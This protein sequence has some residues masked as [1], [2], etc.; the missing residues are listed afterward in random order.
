MTISAKASCNLIPPVM[1]MDGCGQHI[2]DAVPDECWQT[3]FRGELI[4]AHSSDQIQPCDLCVFAVAKNIAART[5]RP[6]LPSGQ[7]SE[8]DTVI[9]A[10]E[11]ASTTHNVLKSFR[12]AGIDTYYENGFLKTRVNLANCDRVRHFPKVE[13]VIGTAGPQIQIPEPSEGSESD[14]RWTVEFPNNGH[15]LDEDQTPYMHYPE[16]PI[17]T[18]EGL[19]FCMVDALQDTFPKGTDH[20]VGAWAPHKNPGTSVPCMTPPFTIP[21]GLSYQ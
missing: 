17:Q 19:S 1:V 14:I 2:D 11:A 15:D 6:K 5:R 13:P 10:I 18:P 8:I 4:P 3:G 9:S 7:L 20:L 12:R 16:E 21:V